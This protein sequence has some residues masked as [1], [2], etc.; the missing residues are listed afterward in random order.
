M[1]AI[2]KSIGKV[3]QVPVVATQIETDL[4]ESHAIHAGVDYLQ[5]YSISTHLTAGNVEEWLR[6]KMG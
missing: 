6:N 1:I 4:M 5:G 2:I 3:I